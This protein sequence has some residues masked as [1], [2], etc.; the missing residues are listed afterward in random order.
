MNCISCLLNFHYPCVYDL[1]K[2]EDIQISM[3]ATQELMTIFAKYSP[4][5]SRNLELK[6]VY[7]LFG[8]LINKN[9]PNFIFFL[10]VALIGQRER[11]IVEAS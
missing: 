10:C 2:Q 5:I 8:K 4:P 6:F 3:I 11:E 1:F 7:L 9:D